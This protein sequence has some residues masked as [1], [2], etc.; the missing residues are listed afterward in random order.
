MYENHVLSIT[1]AVNYLSTLKSIGAGVSPLGVWN[2][3]GA[4]RGEKAWGWDVFMNM[5]IGFPNPKGAGGGVPG[6]VVTG[7]LALVP[8]AFG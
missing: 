3:P 5:F 2:L 4:T 7:I 6:M 1:L 8:W